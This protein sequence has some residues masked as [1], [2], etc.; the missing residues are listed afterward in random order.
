MWGCPW[1]RNSLYR[2]PDNTQAQYG[3][4]GVAGGGAVS[5]KWS[6]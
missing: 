4:P 5:A 1:Q 6:S 3:K 2:G